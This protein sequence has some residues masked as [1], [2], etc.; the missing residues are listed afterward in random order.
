MKPTQSPRRATSSANPFS[1]EPPPASAATVPLAASAAPSRATVRITGP[2]GDAWDESSTHAADFIRDLQAIEADEIRLL[3]NSS[4]GSVM[5]GL[6]IF[7]A[8]S[9]H[10]AH[11]TVQVI[12]G[13]LSIASLIALAGDHVQMSAASV[14]MIHAPWTVAAG[15]APHLRRSADD[16]ERWAAAMSAAYAQRCKRGKK[17]APDEAYF[18]ALLADGQDHFFTAQEALA[19]GLIDEVIDAAEFAAAHD[20]QPPHDLQ[21]HAPQTPDTSMASFGLGLATSCPQPAAQHFKGPTMSTAPAPEVPAH[22]APAAQSPSNTADPAA[23]ERARVAAL[24]GVFAA[25]AD[26]AQALKLQLDCIAR[27]LD[28]HAAR[29]EL[30]AYLGRC[31]APVAGRCVVETVE[32]AA[33]KRRAAQ[34]AAL[35]VRAG[36]ASDAQRRDIGANPLRGHSLL[37][38]ARASLDAAGTHHASWDRRQIVAAAFTQTTSDFPVLLADV[39]HKTLQASYA[40]VQPVW[41]TFCRRSAVSDFRAHRRYRLGSLGTL[42]PKLE[43]AAY[44]VE[45]VPDATATSIAARTHGYIIG[46]SREM[47]INDDLD[48]FVGQA[49]AMGRAAARTVEAAVFAALAENNGMGPKLDDGRPLLHAARGNVA[50]TGAAPSSAAHAALRVLMAQFKDST[51]RDFLDV[52]PHV[53]LG[54]VGLEGAARMVNTSQYEPHTA[55]SMGSLAPNIA[56]GLFAHVVGTPR[57]GGTRYYAF[58]NPADVAALEVAF[59]DGM[60][61]PYIEQ[62]TAFDTDGTRF[63]VRLDFGVAAA[64]WRGIATNAGA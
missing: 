63:K 38:M 59:L 19:A 33:D 27:G 49:A 2:I 5:D 39:M 24:A 9:A 50:A 62:D 1:I 4:G 60:D 11:I 41:P 30:L 44:A 7:N 37:D 42:P 35:M 23:R 22:A 48:A 36:V 21:P 18:A 31:A 8:L 47:I 57:L 17:A 32:D 52:H 14:M 56:Q 54:P 3:I 6:A 28:E 29:A 40:T 43:G 46:L 26:D 51:G 16:L 13:A 53:W 25:F 58:A 12:G 45:N 61:S 20:P 64:D 34:V 10:P 55:G 15:N